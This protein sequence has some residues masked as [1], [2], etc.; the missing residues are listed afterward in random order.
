[1]FEIKRMKTLNV[2]KVNATSI[3]PQDI[4]A[5]FDKENI[6]FTPIDTVNWA[7]YPYR[8]EAS[9][10]I[11]CAEDA[12]LLHYKAS[13]PTVRAEALEDNG[14][15]WEDSCVE[16]FVS[17]DN[18][19]RYYNIECNCA[20]TI[21]VAFGDGRNDR[22]SAPRE[23]LRD[24]LR[25]ASL[26]RGPFE[27]KPAEEP[28]EVALAV[29]FKTFFRHDVASLRGREIRANFYKCG[30]KLRIPHF[31]SWNPIVSERP[32]FHRPEAFGTL[33]VD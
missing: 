4:P 20:G 19:S 11:V 32:D 30:D 13:E 15:V 3:L 33:F 8:P 26:G 12:L 25:Y 31:L 23:L 9:F 5:L 18:D 16:F 14:R 7:D 1:M 2:R 21:L 10:R 22:Q 6:G 29:P 24:V 17:L 27:E 28:W